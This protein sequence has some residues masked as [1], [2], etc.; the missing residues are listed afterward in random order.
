[1]IRENPNERIKFCFVDEYPEIGKA[2]GITALPTIKVYRF[3]TSCDQFVEEKV[4]GPD[5]DQMRELVDKYKQPVLEKQEPLEPA[6]TV[7]EEL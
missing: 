7:D 1:M 2:E 4:V 3:D 6:I 5:S